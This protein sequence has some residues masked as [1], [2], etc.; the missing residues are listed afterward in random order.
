[1]NDVCPISHIPIE[2]ILH[3]VTSMTGPRIVF[4]AEDIIHWLKH[5][6][7]LNPVTNAEVKA[8]LAEH[9]LRCF[10]SNDEA[11]QLVLSRAGYLDGAG[12]KVLFYFILRVSKK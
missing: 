3:P 5:C 8:D 10:E 12:G 7:L 2:E 1:M 6:S 11:T 4:N 9:I